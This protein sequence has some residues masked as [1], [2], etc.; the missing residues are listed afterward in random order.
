M[1]KD[2]GFTLM[3]ILIAMTIMGILASIGLASYTI[4]L[5]KS[6]DAARKSDLSQMARALESYNND[7]G[8]YPRACSGGLIGGCVDGTQACSWGSSFS[9]SNKVYMK[10]LPDD[11]KTGWDYVYLTS[12]DRKSF[13]L[14]TRLENDRDP[15]WVVYTTVCT[16]QSD[17]CT[18]GV[19]SANVELEPPL[20]NEAC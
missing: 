20:T 10:Q 14:F 5:Q 16:S 6:R 1:R 3:E 4:S 7:Y 17:P 18:F 8:T 12:P 9:T 11:K 19:S 15:N 13:Q 2:A